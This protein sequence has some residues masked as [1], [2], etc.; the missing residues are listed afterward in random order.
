[1]ALTP[2]EESRIAE[3]PLYRAGQTSPP[4]KTSSATKT[5]P[6]FKAPLPTPRPLAKSPQPGKDGKPS[7]GKR[8]VLTVLLGGVGYPLLYGSP[9]TRKRT[10]RGLLTAGFLLAL[11]GVSYCIFLPDPV[12]SAKKEMKAIRED[13][14]LDWR[15]KGKKSREVMDNL[16]PRE[17]ADMSKDWRE[18]ARQDL[19]SFFKLPKDQQAAEMK[20]R[21]ERDE[22]RRAE[23]RARFPDGWGGGG[24]GRASGGGGG[25]GGGG[26]AATGGNRGGGGG[27]GGPG[28]GNRGGGGGGGPGGGGPGG[29]GWGGRGGGDRNARQKNFLD[30]STPEERA[31]RGLYR[32]MMNQM[33]QQMGLPTGGRGF[34]GPP[35]RR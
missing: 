30:M 28:A 9:A 29:G 25:G 2:D 33:R 14:N 26:A 8:I 24:G 21:I 4:A 13:P 15:D 3:R 7:L 27:G 17:Q 31:Q 16:S 5:P 18:K 32:G 34:G 19:D 10:L 35:G 23:F 11:T 12:E 20:K 22:K 1:M 6:P